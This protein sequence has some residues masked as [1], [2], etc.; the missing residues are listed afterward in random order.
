MTRDI[1]KIFV[2]TVIPKGR[3]AIIMKIWEILVN[4]LCEIAPE[5]YKDYVVKEGTQED[6]YVEMLKALF[7]VLAASLLYYKK[8][9]EDI[10]STRFCV[11][12]MIHAL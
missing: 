9:R 4:I 8:F 1:P 6:L 2:Q 10:E 3:E 5:V 12:H 11:N 7:G